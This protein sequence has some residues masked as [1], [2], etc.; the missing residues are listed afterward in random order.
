M[1]IGKVNRTVTS[2]WAVIRPRSN[3]EGSDSS[4]ILLTSVPRWIETAPTTSLA[5]AR[6]EIK[7]AGLRSLAAISTDVDWANDTPPAEMVDTSLCATNRIH[8]GYLM[9]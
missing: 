5:G 9:G 8:S 1:R 6:V 2:E 7:L 4:T 3:F